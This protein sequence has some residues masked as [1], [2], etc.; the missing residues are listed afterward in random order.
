MAL[1]DWTTL[2][3]PA[4]SSFRNSGSGHRRRSDAGTATRIGSGLLVVVVACSGGAA[5]A[6]LP[7][8]TQA[9]WQRIG[10]IS[11]GS[12]HGLETC[13]AAIL[14]QGELRGAVD[15]APLAMTSSDHGTSWHSSPLAGASPLLG[16]RS[17]YWRVT[18]DAEGSMQV[19]MTADCGATWTEVSDPSVCLNGNAADALWGSRDS[20]STLYAENRDTVGSV[21]YLCQSDDEGRSWIA[22]PHAPGLV[23]AIRAGRWFAAS[24][25]PGPASNVGAFSRLL[26]SDDRGKSWQS[27]GLESSTNGLSLIRETATEPV[28]YVFAAPRASPR[29]A[30]SVEALWRSVDGGTTWSMLASP[31]SDPSG[32]TYVH[33]L[34][35]NRLAPERM[36]LS[37]DGGIFATVDG[38]RSWSFVDGLPGGEVVL[39]FLFDPSLPGW[40]YGRSDIGLWAM[41]ASPWERGFYSEA[42]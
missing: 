22:G 36:Y 1:D 14:V 6:E 32:A 34:A 38:G 15:P 25:S 23:S 29:G 37:L 7:A 31:Y 10:A 28:V 17:R 21:F 11:G 5:S 24:P 26:Y 19:R 33:A 13:G 9:R 12:L 4:S 42:R 16:D 41:D 30:Q 8:G 40:L 35:V 39:Q 2:H 3:K 27:T 18:R 20:P